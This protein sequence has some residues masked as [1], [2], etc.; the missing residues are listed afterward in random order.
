MT[1]TSVLLNQEERCGSGEG[2]QAVI[3]RSLLTGLE[4]K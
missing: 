3:I 2:V 1:L 4:G